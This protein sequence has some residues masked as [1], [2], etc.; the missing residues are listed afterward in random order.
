MG[1]QVLFEK[2]LT[3]TVGES[4]AVDVGA[5]RPSETSDVYQWAMEN[6]ES[7]TQ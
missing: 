3:I 5:G 4:L 1:S 2:L 6:I 7:E